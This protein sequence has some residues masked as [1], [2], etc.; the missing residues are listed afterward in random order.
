[1]IINLVPAEAWTVKAT[2]LPTIT[3]VCLDIPKAIK[4]V[5]ENP[6]VVFQMEIEPDGKISPIIQNLRLAVIR[7]CKR[8]LVTRRLS[9]TTVFVRLGDPV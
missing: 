1:M 8:L 5:T 4:F 2:P 6:Y 9:P 3:A 7:H